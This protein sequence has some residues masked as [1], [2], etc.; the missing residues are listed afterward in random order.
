LEH[1][2]NF[3]L[4]NLALRTWHFKAL[5]TLPAEV[6]VMMHSILRILKNYQTDISAIR[7]QSL[8]VNK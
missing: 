1:E 3:V 6:N 7:K 8:R 4:G 2:E 5:I